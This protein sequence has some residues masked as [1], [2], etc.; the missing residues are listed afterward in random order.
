[1]KLIEILVLAHRLTL[2][3]RSG[4]CSGDTEKMQLTLQIHYDVPC[5]SVCELDDN[6]LMVNSGALF[7]V[8]LNSVTLIDAKTFSGCL[9]EAEAL[10][11]KTLG[12]EE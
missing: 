9:T 1:M 7:K 5:V 4:L 10:V 8:G 3:T 11:K 2:D 12:I 6:G